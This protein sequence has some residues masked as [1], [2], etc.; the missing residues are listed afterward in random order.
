[1]LFRASLALVTLMALPATA[2]AQDIPASCKGWERI[3]VHTE[4][5]TSG[6]FRLREKVEI[7]CD[8]YKFFADEVDL[9]DDEDRLV[10][11]GNVLFTTPDTRISASRLDFNLETKTGTFYD[12]YGTSKVSPQVGAR[13]IFGTQEADMHFRG[14]TLEK[15]GEKKYRLTDGGFTSCLQPTPRWEFT[16]G[17]ITINI[18]RYAFATNT[19]FRVKGVPLLY[20]PVIYYPLE[21]DSR[22]TGFLMPGYGVSS[23]Q[24][25][26]IRNAFFWAINRSMDLTVG[27]N[28][29]S[30][31]GQAV[32]GEFRYVASDA[33]FGNVQAS[34][35]NEKASSTLLPNGRL[36]ERDASRTT[37]VRGTLTQQLPGRFR[38]GARA[39]YTSSITTRALY[40]QNPYQVTNP[41]SIIDA[42][43]SGTLAGWQIGAQY[44]RNEVFQLGGTT[45]RSTLG[46]TSPR[47]NVSRAESPIGRLPLYWSLQ[48]E[49]VG[50]LDQSR[51]GDTVVERNRMRADIMPALRAPLSKLPWLQLTTSLA[52]RATWWS[53]SLDPETK[54]LVEEPISRNYFELQ[55]NIVGP[56][57]GRIFDT[58]GLGYA[59][60]WKHVVEPS[61]T[62]G[63]T[64]AIDEDV[65]DS[66]FGNESVDN[67]VGSVTRVTYGVTNRL[68]AKRGDGPSAIAREVA[69]L[70]ISQSYYTDP[71]AVE[72]DANYRNTITNEPLSRSFSPLVFAFR[73]S[74]TQ[75]SQLDFTVDYDTQFN[76]IRQLRASTTVRTRDTL[77][78]TAGWSQR[79]VIEGLPGWGES[80]SA[81]SLNANANVRTP[82]NRYSVR[83]GFQYDIKQSELV[84]Q[85]L[86]AHYNAQC[87]GVGLEYRTVNIGR[88]ANRI[89]NRTFNLMFSLAGIGSFSDFFGAFG[90]DPYRRY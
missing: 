58:P 20:L 29:F 77:N 28:F 7:T 85:S 87:C 42:N 52:W 35:L 19:V 17:S 54:E 33:S 5:I 11:T 67:V 43:V 61:I 1:M 53:E 63:R 2:A 68:Y 15:L 75:A 86:S 47:I 83:Y 55:T 78:L 24:G 3:A 72:R 27:H 82:G 76:A 60:R 38:L 46:G 6:H 70:S 51:N 59:Q 48:S 62:F 9:Y 12:A 40:D 73:A 50:I 34:L 14:A 16:S 8:T 81:H 57:F 89:P 80:S 23:V 41:S 74:P 71:L 18:D 44:Y 90:A 31:T 69:S 84:N 13:S 79:K 26:T 21:E 49:G 39:D 56:V 45:E 4:Q 88:G 65:R 25:Q 32:E 37:Q 30:K 10:A 22:A 66:I 36:L 64:T